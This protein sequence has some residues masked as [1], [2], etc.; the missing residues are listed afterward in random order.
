M[1]HRRYKIDLKTRSEHSQLQ[2]LRR[3]EGTEAMPPVNGLT[4]YDDVSFLYC[5]IIDNTIG[6]RSNC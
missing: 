4:N 3:S 1:G 2:S 5:T 6:A